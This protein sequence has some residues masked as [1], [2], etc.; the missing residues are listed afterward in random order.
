[1]PPARSPILP[2]SA[3][4]KLSK[5]PTLNARLR[6]SSRAEE[7][8]AVGPSYAGQCPDRR[9]ADQSDDDCHGKN[10]DRCGPSILCLA[11]AP[12]VVG[13]VPKARAVVPAHMKP[14]K[15]LPSR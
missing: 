4:T 3:P 9:R 6:T 13:Y 10:R 2:R 15:W 11:G 1:M 8:E 14:P 5:V 12:E 7:L